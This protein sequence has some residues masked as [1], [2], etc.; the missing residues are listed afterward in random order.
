MHD[1]IPHFEFLSHIK[2]TILLF[3]SGSKS[4]SLLSSMANGEF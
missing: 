4:V 3:I 1:S 2:T